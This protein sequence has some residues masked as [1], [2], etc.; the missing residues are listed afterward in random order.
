M[1]TKLMFPQYGIPE[2]VISDIVGHH[3]LHISFCNL[4][5]HIASFMLLIALTFLRVMKNR[6]Y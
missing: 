2:K 6:D 3:F 1:H 4:W 5:R